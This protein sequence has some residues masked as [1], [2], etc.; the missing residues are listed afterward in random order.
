[1]KAKSS[2]AL[3]RSS[4]V[5]LG[6]YVLSGSVSAQSPSLQLQI[7]IPDT[8]AGKPQRAE[9]YIQPTTDATNIFLSLFVDET[10]VGS[11]EVRKAYEGKREQITFDFRVPP[12]AYAG[13]HYARL[14]A[15][16]QA[17]K[18]KHT[19]LRAIGFVVKPAPAWG[20]NGY[21][22]TFFFLLA[23]SFLLPITNEV[24]TVFG[25]TVPVIR[26]ELIGSDA[27]QHITNGILSVFPVVFTAL[28][29]TVG[30]A[31]DKGAPSLTYLI[32][33]IIFFLT[34]M[35]WSAMAV[36][37]TGRNPPK[38]SRM[39]IYSVMALVA[40]VAWLLLATTG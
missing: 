18:Q 3:V 21:L 30:G 20:G 27:R 39:V 16:Y 14:E 34:T 26:K 8:I 7:Q 5:L 25:W 11:K 28:T 23:L 40:T 17:A 24:P 1:M 38:A 2:G 13:E 6:V 31:K 10:K 19:E 33:L 29:F 37:Y 15:H 22:P 36:Q 35:F 9:V 32:A 12:S 4:M